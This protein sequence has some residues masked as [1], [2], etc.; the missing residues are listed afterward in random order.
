MVD[1]WPKKDR[2]EDLGHGRF[3]TGSLAGG[4]DNGNYRWMHGEILVRENRFLKRISVEKK[5]RFD[6]HHLKRLRPGKGPAIR[7]MTGQKGK[8]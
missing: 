8:K 6:K 3:H 5:D 1:H 2:M 4:K 7:A